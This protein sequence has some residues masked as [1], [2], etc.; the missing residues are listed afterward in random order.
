LGCRISTRPIPCLGWY[1]AVGLARCAHCG[2]YTLWPQ[3]N[4]RAGAKQ[5]LCLLYPQLRCTSLHHSLLMLLF[6]A[7]CVFAGQPSCVPGCILSRSAAA[8]Q[9][10]G[11]GYQQGCSGATTSLNCRCWLGQTLEFTGLLQPGVPGHCRYTSCVDTVTMTTAP[12]PQ[13]QWPGV[14]ET[15]EGGP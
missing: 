8:V 11:A 13:H 5:I 15:P 12:L 2:V 6:F 14:Q 7:R 3:D 4:Q 1:T 10:G 9:A